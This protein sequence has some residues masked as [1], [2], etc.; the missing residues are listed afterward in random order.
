MLDRRTLLKGTAFAAASSIPGLTILSSALAA[1]PQ[2]KL[3]DLYNK[4]MSFSDFAKEHDGK[5]ILVNGFMAPP[6]KA[7]SK[8]FVLTKMPMA[9]CPFCEPETDWPD[10]ILAVYARR[11]VDVI[12]FNRKII[13]QGRLQLGGYSDPETG[14]YSMVRLEDAKYERV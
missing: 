12:P 11:T 6:L 4:D 5:I 10:D 13:T 3:R 9:V 8:F 2:I 7:E 1:P 14:F